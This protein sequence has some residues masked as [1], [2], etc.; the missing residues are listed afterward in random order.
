MQYITR[1]VTIGLL[2]A[3]AA[4]AQ[5]SLSGRVV[6]EASAPVSAAEISPR[7]NELS[8]R[9]VWSA[10]PISAL[11]LLTEFKLVMATLLS[12]YGQQGAYR[13]KGQTP[14]R[15]PPPESGIESVVGAE[16]SAVCGMTA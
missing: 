9:T 8:C 7:S 5:V 14:N 6:D 1:V 16:F 10:S 4:L 15:V 2:A 3:G 11:V 12:R 13:G